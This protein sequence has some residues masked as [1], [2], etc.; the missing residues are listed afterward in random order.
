MNLAFESWLA[1]RYLKAKKGEK[2]LSVITVFSLLGITLG[3]ATLI[4]VMS[5]MN[6]F[7]QELFFRILGFNGHMTVTESFSANALNDYDALAKEFERK[8]VVVSATPIV[9]GQVM[10]TANNTASG[11]MVRGLSADEFLQSPLLSK[12]LVA[13]SIANFQDEKGILLGSRMAERFWVKPGD[14]VTLI[15]PQSTV[16]AFG[17]VPRSKTYTVAGIFQIGMYE[18]DN[19]IILMPLGLAQTYFK[20]PGRVSAIELKLTDPFL[21][22]DP[23]VRLDLYSVVPEGNIN[24]MTWQQSHRSFFTAIEVERNVMFLIL[25]LIILVAAFNIISMLIILVKE[26]RGNIAILRAMGASRGS[27]MRIFLMT[28]LSIGVFGTLFG[29]ALGVLFAENIEIIRTW[30]QSLTGTDLF[31][32]EIYFLSQLPAEVDWSE[33]LTVVG[34]SLVLSLLATLYPSWKAAKTDPVEILRYE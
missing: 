8:D 4:I 22:T 27:I 21:A 25:T 29:F 7:R 32:A 12:S 31:S 2:F 10:V 13:G 20:L 6:G 19:N 3:V 28:G 9:E 11:A 14:K 15:S 30:L 24:L 26:K 34:M 18:Y 17:S 16:T 23:D 1:W 33:V 5:V